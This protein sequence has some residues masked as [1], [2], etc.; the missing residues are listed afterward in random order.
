MARR[1]V[2]LFIESIRIQGF[3]SL[4]D[5][6]LRDLAPVNVFHGANDV[7]KS[8]I[9]Q[10]LDLFFQVVPVAARSIEDQDSRLA[11]V[12]AALYSKHLSAR[13]ER[14]HCMGSAPETA[15]VEAR[16]REALPEATGETIL[17]AGEDKHQRLNSENQVT[18]YQEVIGDLGLKYGDMV[19]FVKNAAGRW[20]LQHER[21]ALAELQ[22]AF[23]D[24]DGD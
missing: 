17:P 19:V 8:N 2:H 12:P 3:K 4:Q 7:G 11:Q 21:E 18:L 22:E 13:G 15:A 20:E 23:R 24:L 6:E 5:I 16:G 9:L 1:E 10:A 14:L